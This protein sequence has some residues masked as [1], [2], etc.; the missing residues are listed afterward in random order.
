MDFIGVDTAIMGIDGLFDK[1]APAL[2]Q[3]IA[4]YIPD[5]T[6]EAMPERLV[7]LALFYFAIPVCW[8]WMDDYFKDVAARESSHQSSASEKKEMKTE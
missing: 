2:I 8:D 7:S 6:W 3:T 1:Y 5:E 4:A